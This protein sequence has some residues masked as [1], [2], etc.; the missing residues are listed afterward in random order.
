MPKCRVSYPN[1]VERL[2]RSRPRKLTFHQT[3]SRCRAIEFYRPISIACF[4][5]AN[6]RSRIARSCTCS[7]CLILEC[8][9]ACVRVFWNPF[10]YSFLALELPFSKQLA[11]IMHPHI[12]VPQCPSQEVSVVSGNTDVVDCGISKLEC[13]ASMR[14]SRPASETN[15]SPTRHSP[16]G[17]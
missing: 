3:A 6:E 1:S 2:N 7:T 5:F 11:G 15:G 14:R 13:S 10:C 17:T 9:F 8:I 12:P 4:V 16:E